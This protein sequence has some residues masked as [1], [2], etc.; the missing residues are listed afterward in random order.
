[1]LTVQEKRFKKLNLCLYVK[2]LRSTIQKISQKEEFVVA[3]DVYS[4]LVPV[5]FSKNILH[6]LIKTH[7]LY[8]YYFSDDCG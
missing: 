2:H 3:R 8:I 6:R 4:F 5:S 1:M 7:T